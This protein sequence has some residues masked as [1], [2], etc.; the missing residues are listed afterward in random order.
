M[1]KKALKSALKTSANLSQF[2][3]SVYRLVISYISNFG[4]FQP[5]PKG[6]LRPFDLCPQLDQLKH[7]VLDYLHQHQ[8]PRGLRHWAIAWQVHPLSRLPHLDILLY[9]QKN[10][11]KTPT[12][13]NI[14]LKRLNII[15]HK[16]NDPTFTGGANVTAYSSRKFS[17]AIAQYG[18]KEDPAVLSNLPQDLQPLVKAHKL[19]AE[20]YRFL[21][22]Q[23]LKDPLHF[24]LQQYVRRN[25]LNQYLSS[26]SSLK[27]RL[28]DSQLAAANLLLKER[29]GFKFIT[30]QLIQKKLTP[31]ELK[32]FDSWSGYQTIVNHLNQ[33]PTYSF[34]RP[35]KTMNLLITGP[36]SIGKTTLI[37]N[38]NHDFS[39]SCIEDTTAVYHMGMTNW[40]P[41]YQSN[42]YSIIFWNEAKLT[43]YAY[44]TILKV[45]EGS[46]CDLPT[47]GSSARKVD[48]PLI[49][50]TS[51]MTLEQMI[52]Q[53]FGYNEEYQNMARANL[54]VR[55]Q[56]VIV[57]QGYN[58]FL[59]QKLLVPDYQQTYQN[60]RPIAS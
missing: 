36:A 2:D 11:K 50:M 20:P 42:V 15:Q 17:K 32:T 3:A 28:K 52:K 54:K 1:P 46:H 18:F 51:N 41:R 10:I 60:H 38:P 5:S 29:P 44:D 53:K 48:N 4:Q 39:Q 27:G 30:R 57:P 7:R 37:H 55:V 22:L 25:D 43:S 8:S 26:W 40:F 19:K 16:P 12:S 45:L 24:N 59:L 34:R 56:N 33:V 6:T 9:Y 21:E 31:L 49:I 35:L 14:M 23:M 58:L 47:K 13:F